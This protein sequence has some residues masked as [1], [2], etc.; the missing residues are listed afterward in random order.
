MNHGGERLQSA[1]G[2]FG[3]SQS[4]NLT[5]VGGIYYV[6]FQSAICSNKRLMAEDV[7]GELASVPLRH[8]PDE[9]ETRGSRPQAT[10]AILA[11][12][13]DIRLLVILLWI[14]H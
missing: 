14:M 8:F 12:S 11:S 7:A 9:R 10:V 3:V 1:H 6:P 5:A 13:H 4:E 2:Y